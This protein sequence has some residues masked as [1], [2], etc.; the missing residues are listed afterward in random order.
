M[1]LLINPIE[2]NSARDNSELIPDANGPGDGSKTKSIEVHFN[3][4]I[5]ELRSYQSRHQ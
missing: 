1:S 5:Q 3:G 4:F 2:V